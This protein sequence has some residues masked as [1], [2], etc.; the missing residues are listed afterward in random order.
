VATTFTP[1]NKE[2]TLEEID[3]F[4]AAISNII[5]FGKRTDKKKAFAKVDEW[6]DK[7]L[8]LEGGE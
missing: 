7:R 2:Y 6:L 1:V 5:K 4:L 3:G 8:D